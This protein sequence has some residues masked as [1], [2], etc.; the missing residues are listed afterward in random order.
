MFLVIF[1]FCC[2]DHEWYI[3]TSCWDVLNVFRS[4]NVGYKKVFQIKYKSVNGNVPY[5]WK[6]L[7]SHARYIFLRGFPVARENNT[8]SS[9]S[10]LSNWFIRKI[11]QI[12]LLSLRWSVNIYEN[13]YWWIIYKSVL[14][15]NVQTFA[16]RLIYNS[17]DFFLLSF[18]VDFRW[19]FAML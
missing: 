5:K 8:I 7:F 11:L 18:S 13:Q 14:F 19:F 1:C 2:Y 10:Q 6:C 4:W 9:L 3:C 12:A 15:Y 16:I 17:P